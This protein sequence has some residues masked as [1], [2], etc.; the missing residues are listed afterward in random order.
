MQWI[1]DFFGVKAIIAVA[2]AAAYVLGWVA[3]QG[4]MYLLWT[5]LNFEAPAGV[6]TSVGYALA[7]LPSNT[8][9]CLSAL[10]S[11]YT[12]RWLWRRQAEWMRIFTNAG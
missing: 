1:L 6:V 3:L 12:A 9:A 8:A 7:M 11:A 10:V 2:V 5:G 4:A